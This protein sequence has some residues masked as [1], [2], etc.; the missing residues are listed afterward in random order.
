MSRKSDTALSMIGVIKTSG[1]YIDLKEMK[2]MSQLK[3]SIEN[4]NEISKSEYDT[5]SRLYRRT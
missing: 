5:I 2:L 3:E 4:G 1:I